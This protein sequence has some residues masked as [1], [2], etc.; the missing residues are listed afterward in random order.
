MAQV[1]ILQGGGTP[2]DQVDLFEWEGVGKYER[3][4]MIQTLT[5]NLAGYADHLGLTGDRRNRFLTNGAAAIK[6]LEAGQLKRLADG[7]YSDAS[8]TMS[9]TGKYDKNWLGRLKDTDNNAYNDIAGYFDAYMGKASVYDPEKA[10][11]EAE[12]KAKEGKTKFT[13]DTY[14]RDRLA[15]KYY[16][17]T[18]NTAD[19]FDHRDETGRL[20][21]IADELDAADYNTI[22]GKYLWDN[23][24]IDSA[25]TLRA[26]AQALSTNLRN[27]KLDNADYNTA[28]ALGINLDTFLKKPNEAP[29]EPTREEQQAS[30]KKA[31]IK[32]QLDAGYSQSEAER[33]WTLEQNQAARQR[34]GV[35]KAAEDAYAQQLED[36]EWESWY[37]Q[38]NN[39]NTAGL[40]QAVFGD[41]INWSDDSVLDRI[42]KTYKG[43]TS[44]YYDSVGRILSGKNKYT[45]AKTDRD[46]QIYNLRTLRHAY[47]NNPGYF[48]NELANGEYII[49]GTLNTSNYT[50]YVFNPS[51]NS[52]RQVNLLSN[53]TY[54][55]FARG[56]WSANRKASRKEG[57]IIKMQDGGYADYQRSLQEGRNASS[58]WFQDAYGAREQRRAAEKKQTEQKAQATG[59]T[60]EQYTAGQKQVGTEFTTLEKV[61][62]GTAA[63]DV[64]S[65]I[66]AFVPGYGTAASAVTGVASTLTGFGADMY[67]DS[68]SAGQMWGNLG[69]GLGLDVIGLIPGL[70]AG[71]KAGKIAKVF[72]KIA[73]KALLA[74]GAYEGGGP[75]I[76]AANKL[77]KDSSSMTVDDWRALAGGLQLLAGGA[78]YAAG[79]R[80]LNKFTTQQ[81]FVQVRAKDGRMI[82]M[83]PE[84]FDQLKNAKGLEAQNKV[85]KSIDPQAELGKEFR[86]RS[87]TH[88]F[89]TGPQTSKGVDRGFVDNSGSATI[90]HDEMLFR[91]IAGVDTRINTPAWMRGFG[92]VSNPNYNGPRT[93]TTRAAGQPPKR[94]IQA[95]GEGETRVRQGN[96]VVR[97][98]QLTDAEIKQINRNRKAAGQQPLTQKEIDAINAR[99]A[100]NTPTQAPTLQERLQQRRYDREHSVEAEVARARAELEAAN[101]IAQRPVVAAQAPVMVA[102]QTVPARMSLQDFIN[103]GIPGRQSSGAA[104]ASRQRMYET[105]WPSSTAQ[106]SAQTVQPRMSTRQVIDQRVPKRTTPKGR[107]KRQKDLEAAFADPAQFRGADRARFMVQDQTRPA[108]MTTKQLIESR[109]PKKPATGAAR[110]NRQKIL[111]ELLGPLQRADNRKVGAQKAAK[112]RAAK[113]KAKSRDDKLSTINGAYKLGGRLIP[114]FKNPS[115]P[116]SNTKSTANWLTD[117]YG[118]DAMARWLGSYD[119]NNYGLFNTLQQQY[120]DNLQATG[121]DPDKTTKVSYNQGVYDRQ[122]N[123]N[124]AAGGI[125]GVIE[126]LAGPNGK[127][128]RA[129]TTGDNA[130]SAH[131]FQDGYFGFQE[132]LRHGGTKTSGLSEAQLADINKLV[133][134]KNLEYYFDPTTGMGM[135]KPLTKPAAD[136][137]AKA[138]TPQPV[139]AGDDGSGQP[140]TTARAGARKTKNDGSGKGWN[141]MPEDVLATSRALIGLG[142]NARAAR[143]QKAGMRPLITDTWE[144]VVSPEWD[145]F[146]QRAGEDAYAGMTSFAGRAR[147]ANSQDQFAGQLEAENKGR[148]FIVQGNQQAANRF[149]STDRLRQQESDAA[150]A[151]RVENANANTGRML[152]VDAAKHQIDAALTTAQYAQI[153]A[154]WMAGIENQYRQNRAAQR[155]MDA[156]AYQRALLASMQADYDKAVESG[157][158]D[159]VKRVTDQYYKDLQEYN[160]RAYSNPWL[161]QRTTSMPQSGFTF[162][163]K[164]GGRLTAREKEVIQRARDFNKRMLADNKQFHKDIMESKR[165]HNKLIAGM[166]NLT[167]D[168]IKSGMKWK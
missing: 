128:T 74:W 7:S 137:G 163:A 26:R 2:T 150:K 115:G 95:L 54:K 155:Q 123:F 18:F 126:T 144:N 43:N 159:A 6:A 146:A 48:G 52:Y 107:A 64:L 122:G 38:H 13:G 158:K 39:P 28:A 29:K 67:D 46:T 114:R 30:A 116:I 9:S 66:S 83:T 49:P 82:K 102:N 162:V 72:A 121:F 22:Y 85:L 78:R 73:P 149:Y 93:S 44:D 112:T 90:G 16:A 51:S 161:I 37:S 110:K 100:N 168:L 133:G 32:Q 20:I 15:Q 142:V 160:S 135:L 124:T 127:I 79:K 59:R 108:R 11:K 58:A 81:E 97:T 136:Q 14:L 154:P 23:T 27:G 35:M 62:L 103:S 141:L 5:K 120:Y 140:S 65:A 148:Q 151:R 21:G 12:A 69:M 68:V 166:S 42:Q 113:K 1:K 76:A 109:L 106:V 134:A 87:L 118:T 101:R 86:G 143:Q 91:R 63:A 105:L 131:P 92:Q 117:I 41:N 50:A 96:N 3:K 33:L 80:R 130:A 45:E 84:Q 25:D 125:N 34:S 70:G 55:N 167:A 8:G 147:T 132:Y 53:S 145:Y 57:G 60:A 47:A 75:A 152:A 153:L 98:G 89:K 71:A 36:D 88:P 94:R 19:W 40:A 4:P 119:E 164:E 139:T 165:E 104:R 138:D 31:F 56:I 17:G 77:M 99:A 157:D 111:E 156:S 129:G 61:R 24:G 10:K